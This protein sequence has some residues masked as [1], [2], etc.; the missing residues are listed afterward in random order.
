MN[1]QLTHMT[2]P[3]RRIAQTTKARLSV[4]VL[5]ALKETELNV[6]VMKHSEK[7][8]QLLVHC[9]LVFKCRYIKSTVGRIMFGTEEAVGQLDSGSNSPGSSPARVQCVLFLAVTFLVLV[10]ASKIY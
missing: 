6:R 9:T 10:S 7:A 8:L 3:L 5:M 4:P 2:V 1:A